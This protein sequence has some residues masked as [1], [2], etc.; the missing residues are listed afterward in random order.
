[1][2]EGELPARLLALARRDLRAALP[3]MTMPTTTGNAR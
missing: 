1:M 2:S 3:G